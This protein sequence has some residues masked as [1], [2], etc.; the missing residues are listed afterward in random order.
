[1]DSRNEAR[2]RYYQGKD[3]PKVIAISA[4]TERFPASMF[5]TVVIAAAA[6]AWLMA[7]LQ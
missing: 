7:L 3:E 5:R 6:Y 1:M 4:T 2:N